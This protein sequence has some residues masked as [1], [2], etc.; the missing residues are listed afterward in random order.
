MTYN[1]HSGHYFLTI[2][3]YEP[4]KGLLWSDIL[5]TFSDKL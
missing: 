4:S 2:S 1:A 5:E 3:G